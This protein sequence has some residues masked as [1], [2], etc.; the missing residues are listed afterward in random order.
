MKKK[1][2][3]DKRETKETGYLQGCVGTEWKE[4]R[5]GNGLVRIEGSD[6]NQSASF[7]IALVFRTMVIF[8]IICHE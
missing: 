3:K 4:W 1:N 8:H 6:T 7:Y 5:N 2:R